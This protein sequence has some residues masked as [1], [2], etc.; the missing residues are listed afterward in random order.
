MHVI[1]NNDR[2]KLQ[3]K[4]DIYEKYIKKIVFVLMLGL[5][6]HEIQ[7]AQVIQASAAST[8]AWTIKKSITCIQR[9]I[10]QVANLARQ[11]APT[12]IAGVAILFLFRQLY[13]TRNKPMIIK[14]AGK[15]P[16]SQD[17]QTPSITPSCNL[18]QVSVLGQS[19]KTCGVHAV[20]N[21]WLG[22][23]IINKNQESINRIKDNTFYTETFPQDH[24]RD[25][26]QDNEVQDLVRRVVPEKQHNNIYVLQNIEQ[27][28]NMFTISDQASVLTEECATMA[29]RLSQPSYIV[30]FVTHNQRRFTGDH[31]TAFTVK[32]ENGFVRDIIFM[33]SLNGS[34]D[35]TTAINLLTMCS[36]N[37]IEYMQQLAEYNSNIS[38][39]KCVEKIT[40]YK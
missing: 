40:R 18:R 39:H 33:D 5:C 37:K 22:L 10:A 32:K 29:Y 2:N 35:K 1:I 25:D 36:K 16:S 15:N 30:S 31:W 21:A 8:M 12:A 13:N 6:A 19:G 23:S 4:K 27:V 9:C 20:K 24:L 17:Q 11:N 3:C 34:S 26:L 7:A 28:V 38:A 14:L